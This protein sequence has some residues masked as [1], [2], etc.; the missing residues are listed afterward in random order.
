MSNIFTFNVWFV[1]SCVCVS[2]HNLV[3]NVYK[4]L[5]TKGRYV[6]VTCLHKHVISIVLK[7]DQDFHIFC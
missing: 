4:D 5:L 7:I 2:I 3:I 1:Y 6:S